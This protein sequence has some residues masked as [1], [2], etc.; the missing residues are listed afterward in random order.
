MTK[1]FTSARLADAL[2]A[3]GSGPVASP[4]PVTPAIAA[5]ADLIDD[6]AVASMAAVGSRSGRDVVGKVWKLFLSQAPEAL[7]K[8]ETLLAGNAD[9]EALAR[10][11]HFLKS[12]SLSAGATRLAALCERVEHEGKSGD[13]NAARRL[14]TG[15][16]P[17][18][19]AT[20]RQMSSRLATRPAAVAAV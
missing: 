14:I 10:Q 3:A 7:A 5:G 2:K 1:P 12:M 11:V 6:D 16:R 4:A 19:E 8:L 20:C 18:V 9:P 13:P 15:L 17:L